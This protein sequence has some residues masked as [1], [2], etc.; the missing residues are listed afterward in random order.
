MKKYKFKA[1]IVM[2][3]HNRKQLVIDIIDRLFFPSLLNNALKNVEIIIIDDCSTLKNETKKMFLK[4][5]EK[6]KKSFGQLRYIVNKT[7]L[8]FSGSYNKGMKLAQGE[9]IIII[10]DDVYIPRETIKRLI[11]LNS[12]NREYGIIGPVLNQRNSFTY[13]YAKQSPHISSYSKN[14]LNKCE[15]FSF[16]LRKMFN[17]QIIGTDYITG[18]CWIMHK[19]ILKDI[20]YFDENFKYGNYEDIDFCIRVSKKYKI[21]LAP[22]Y[23]DH[24]GI[25][26]AHNSTTQQK[27]FLIK[28]LIKNLYYLNSKHGFKKTS[29]FLINGLIRL[30][31]LRNT[32]SDRIEKEQ[33]NKK[34]HSKSH[35]PTAS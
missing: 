8:G 17:N 4:Y 26:G 30:L 27:I 31:F 19:E 22:L 13:Q 34:Q 10:N 2:S 35:Q 14:E 3:M 21:G 32:I 9:Y 16:K 33:K 5:S 12:K 11:L 29:T 7:N 20:G 15:D 1:S 24:G 6:L 25:M 23:I 18:C 28:N